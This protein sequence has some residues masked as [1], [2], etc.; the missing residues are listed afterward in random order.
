[1]AKHKK[2][3][4]PTPEEGYKET[5]KHLLAENSQLKT[6]LRNAHYVTV[7]QFVDEYSGAL[8]D[9]I[10]SQYVSYKEP[11]ALNHPHDLATAAINFAEAVWYMHEQMDILRRGTSIGKP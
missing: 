8:R 3:E 5:I 7:D 2:I 11:N 4:E 1:M 6:D 10:M 9:Y